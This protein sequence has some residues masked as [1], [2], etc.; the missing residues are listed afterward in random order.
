M[1]HNKDRTG[2]TFK[3][4]TELKHIMWD[5]QLMNK[6]VITNGNKK[7]ELAYT[8]ASLN[9]DGV[10]TELC[11][12]IEI[13]HQP[14][15]KLVFSYAGLISAATGGYKLGPIVPYMYGSFH[16]TTLGG[17]SLENTGNFVYEKDFNL[18]YKVTGD[19]VKKSMT[20]CFGFLAV[21]N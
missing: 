16:F 9:K 6:W 8:P 1:V 11:H 10:H 4:K 12:D 20:E 21:K 5:G 18:G 14:A 7:V 15:S 2:H 19:I 17:R 3:S 13:V